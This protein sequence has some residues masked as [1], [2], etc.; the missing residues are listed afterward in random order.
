[1][2]TPAVTVLPHSGA[3]GTLHT[4]ARVHGGVLPQPVPSSPLRELPV[5]AE[6]PFVPTGS[7]SGGHVEGPVF[8]L[9]TS[10]L[11]EA[12]AKRSRAVAF[13]ACHLPAPPGAQPGVT[14]D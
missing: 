2:P 6:F 1:M 13:G 7:A 4:P 11:I 10:T 5:P 3:H 12:P 14:P 9:P 8:G